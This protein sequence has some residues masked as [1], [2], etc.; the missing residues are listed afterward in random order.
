MVLSLVFLK[1]YCYVVLNS[2]NCIFIQLLTQFSHFSCH[3]FTKQIKL[4]LL[5]GFFVVAATDWSTSNSSFSIS[6]P[7]FVAFCFPFLSFV[8]IS[9]G[10]FT[11]LTCSSSHLSFF[12]LIVFLSLLLGN[13]VFFSINTDKTF[14]FLF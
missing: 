14:A 12:S 10:F 13:I 2:F 6:V 8:A 5:S 4:S 1:N 7:C 3:A 11:L 9:F